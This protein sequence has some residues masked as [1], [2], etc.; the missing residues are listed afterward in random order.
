MRHSPRLFVLIGMVL[1]LIP[2]RASGQDLE[3][4]GQVSGELRGFF[5]GPQFARQF[6]GS[7]PS[8]F[9]LPELEFDLA[10]GRDQFT[11]VPFFRIDGRDSG[12]THF[13]IREAYWRHS[14]AGWELLVGL[15]RV[16]W[17]VAESRHLVDV[18]NQ[19]DFVED[20]DGED[21]LGQPMVSLRIQR[22]WGSLRFFALPGFRERSFPDAEG[23]P[24][25]PLAVDADETE[26]DSSAGRKHVDYAVRYS[27]Y[28]GNWDVG[29]AYFRGT[30]REPVLLPNADGTALIPLYRQINQGSLDV[31]YTKNSWLWKFEGIVREGHGKTFAAA[32]GGAEYTLYQIAGTGADLGFLAEYQFDGRGQDAPF[33][34]AND[35]IFA[36]TRLALNDT[37][38]TQLLAGA[39][40]DRQHGSSA[41]LVELERRMAESW[42]V[43]FESRMFLNTNPADALDTFGRDGWATLRLSWFF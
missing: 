24:G 35:D 19:I 20:V 26:Y 4:F 13:D 29:V 11:F 39:I 10:G 5:Q 15:D 23:R 2:D 7:Q 22:N 25:F 18:I 34:T 38:D 40:V 33:T 42:L 43:E 8:L 14:A 41:V 30:D 28:W 21:K 27:N 6:S 32:V 1:V 37:Q 3:V 31:Q 12:R 9:F 36:G 16:F 17:G